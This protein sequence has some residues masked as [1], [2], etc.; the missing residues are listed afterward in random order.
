MPADLGRDK[1]ESLLR[2]HQKLGAKK[3]LVHPVSYYILI[4]IKDRLNAR[5]YI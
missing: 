2:L 4:G 1:T 5:N 3:N